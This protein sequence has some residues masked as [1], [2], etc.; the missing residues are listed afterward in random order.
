MFFPPGLF[1]PMGRVWDSL[2]EH[3]PSLPSDSIRLICNFFLLLGVKDGTG[4]DVSNDQLNFSGRAVVLILLIVRMEMM[5]KRQRG[6]VCF[7]K[8]VRYWAAMNVNLRCGR[9]VALDGI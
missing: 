2:I 9:K 1:L 6:F 8:V 7:G 4:F 3:R 5:K